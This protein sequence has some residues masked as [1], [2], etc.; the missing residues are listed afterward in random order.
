[1]AE[2]PIKIERRLISPLDDFRKLWLE[3]DRLFKEMTHVKG[4]E[5]LS[6]Y[7]EPLTDIKETSKEIIITMDLPGI[8]KEGVQLVVENNM[9]EI[10]AERKEELQ[11]EKKA[12]FRHERHYQG[13]YRLLSLPTQIDAEKSSAE[14]KN[15]VLTITA[16]KIAKGIRGKKLEIK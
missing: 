3:M 1:M 8:K 16:P 15:G 7:R 14:Y 5:L 6:D 2:E 10:K 12:V 9:I 11:G 4:D 13:F